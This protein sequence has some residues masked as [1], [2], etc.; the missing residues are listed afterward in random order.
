VIS[1][2]VVVAGSIGLLVLGGPSSNHRLVEAHAVTS[3]ESAGLPAIR[4]PAAASATWCGSAA[5][6]DVVPNVVAGVP[7]HWLYVMP[8][9][10]PDRLTTY[11]SVMQTDADAIDA[12]WRREDPTRTPRND[13]RSLSCGNQLDISSL[14]LQQTGLDLDSDFNFGDI[15]DGIDAAGFGSALTK[16]VVYYDGPASPTPEGEVCG[17]GGSIPSGLGLAVV[18]VRACLGVSTAAV[19]AHE[20]LHTLGAVPFAAPNACDG[21]VCDREDDL[22]YPF[23]GQLPL[24]A[25]LLDP[26]RDDY[27]AHSGA[28]DDAQDSDWLVRLNAQTPLRVNVS[29][30]G[31][32]RADVP[33]LQCARTCTTTWNTGTRLNLEATPSRSTKLVRWS[34]ACSGTAGCAVSVAPG[35]TVTALFAPRRYRLAVSVGGKGSIQS[36]RGGIAC[37]RRCAAAVSSHVPV[38]LTAKPAKGWRLRAWA[39]ACRGSRLSCTV[40]MTK[41][42]TAR[43]VFVRALSR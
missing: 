21:H 23:L 15:L 5:A 24:D 29:G 1:R 37:G 32:V 7:I 25:K 43:A 41:V 20:I 26:G 2:V 42:T 3:A 9:D 34:G 12:W 39:G 35:R 33:G 38:R 30:T 27:Y 8:S 10:G 22:M 6:A 28:Q 19:A 4:T 11:A 16:Y 40:Q 18:Y 17:R 36:S 14:R 13:L 31:S